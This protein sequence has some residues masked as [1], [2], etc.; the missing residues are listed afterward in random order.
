MSFITLTENFSLLLTAQSFEVWERQNVQFIPDADV[1]CDTV[2]FGNFM[3]N[4]TA[5]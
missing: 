2:Q 1:M 4:Y 3:R 5:A